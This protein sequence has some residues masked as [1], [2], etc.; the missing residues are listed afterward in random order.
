LAWLRK[1]KHPREHATDIRLRAERRLGEMMSRQGETVG[2]AKGKQSAKG[3]QKN[4]LG[5]P[6][7]AEAGIDKNLADR[8]RKAARVFK[9]PMLVLQNTASVKLRPGRDQQVHH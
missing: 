1:G 3:F 9:K 8:A 2:V 6:S 7:L 4:P 5:P